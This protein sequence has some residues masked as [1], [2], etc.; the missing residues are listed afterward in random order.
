MDKIYIGDGVY[1]SYDG[2]QIK[3]QTLE[4]K[5][6]YLDPNTYHTMIETVKRL[7]AEE[8]SH[9]PTES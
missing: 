1:L 4:G 9:G 5:V 2:Y 6:I 3:L 8:E 7:H